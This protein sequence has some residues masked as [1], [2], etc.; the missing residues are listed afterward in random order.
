MTRPRGLPAFAETPL[1]VGLGLVSV[2]AGLIPLSPGGEM[3]APD[4]LYALMIAW[5]VRRPATTPLWLAPA[6]GLFADLMLARPVGLGA[7]GLMLATEGFRARAGLF[8]DTPFLIEWAAAALGFAALLAA[9]HLALQIVFAT[10]PSIASLAGYLIA[11]AIAYPLVVLGLTW[12][13]RL[14]APGGH[15]AG[16]LERNR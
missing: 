5:I 15:R 6:L 7:L 1:L 4:L 2:L 8:H 11:T 12:C 9:M 14:G 16:A 3:V 13:L 10:P